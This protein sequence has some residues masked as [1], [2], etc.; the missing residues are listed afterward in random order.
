M[1][2]DMD[3]YSSKVCAHST[4]IKKHLSEVFVTALNFIF[5]DNEYMSVKYDLNSFVKKQ[6]SFVTDYSSSILLYQLCGTS[7]LKWTLLLRL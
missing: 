2:T 3:N 5:L 4:F 1:S 7:L 6:I